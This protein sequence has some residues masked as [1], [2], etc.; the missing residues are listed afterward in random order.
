MT[1]L[2]KIRVWCLSSILLGLGHFIASAQCTSPYGIDFNAITQKSVKLSWLDNNISKVGFDIDIAPLSINPDG[3]ADYQLGGNFTSFTIEGLQSSTTYQVYLKTKCSTGNA[4]AWNGPFI[5]TTLLSNPTACGTLLNLRDNGQE[6]YYIDVKE[7]G[8]LGTDIFLES[9]DMIIAHGWPADLKISIISPGQKQVI[10]SEHHGTITDN[11]GDPG[12]GTCTRFCQ[13]SDDGCTS[14]QAQAPPFIGTFKPDQPL[15]TFEDNSSVKGLWQLIIQDRAIF[16]DGILKYVNLRFSKQKCQTPEQIF[17]DGVNATSAV[18][19]WQK[20]SSCQT[21]KIIIEECDKPQISRKEYFV[22]CNDQKFKIPGLFPDRCYSVTLSA[23]C[24]SQLSLPSCQTSFYTR[25]KPITM[26]EHFNSENTCIEG[27]QFSCKLT[28]LWKNSI[29][30]TQDW[31]AWAGPTDTDQTGP[32]GDIAGIGKYLYIENQPSLCPSREPVILESPCLLVQ[33]AY[34]GCDMSFFT[35]MYGAGIQSIKLDISTNGG[36]S[37]DEVFKKDKETGIDWVR[38]I[39]DLSA[40]DKKNILM[41][42]TAYTSQLVT[43]DIAL[44]QIEFYGSTVN[45]LLPRYFRDEDNDGYGHPQLYIDVCTTTP[46]DGYVTNNKDCNDAN[47]NIYPGAPEITCNLTDENCNGPDDDND[48][49]NTLHLDYEIVEVSCSGKND[50][51]IELLIAGGVTEV[52]K[53]KLTA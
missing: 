52:T 28:G 4:S 49:I 31:I 3:I 27:C 46:P 12:D 13:F 8:K 45:N 25:C 53:L 6:V 42:F 23:V 48:P 14:L 1:I 47:P 41:Q 40:Y 21:V 26:E 22:N 35:H 2:F 19:N 38:N 15:Y 34:D 16:D 17:I 30:N 50:G 5:F 20:K 51:A 9:V 36:I 11:F 24:G 37:W 33:S 32:S 44:D 29:H 7:E 43:G 10:L 39:L 18:I